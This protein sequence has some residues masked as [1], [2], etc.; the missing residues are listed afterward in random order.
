MSSDEEI[1]DPYGN[2]TRAPAVKGLE[3]ALSETC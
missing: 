1:G 2:R 3:L